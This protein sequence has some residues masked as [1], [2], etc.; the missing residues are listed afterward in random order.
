MLHH[1]KYVLSYVDSGP[2]LQTLIT[3][4]HHISLFLALFRD[5]CRWMFQHVK[6]FFMI[7]LR[8]RDFY[9]YARNIVLQ[10]HVT[11]RFSRS[12]MFEKEPALNYNKKG[13]TCS[14]IKFR[15]RVIFFFFFENSNIWISVTKSKL[16]LDFPLSGVK[17][18]E[19]SLCL[20]CFSPS[21][22]KISF[23]L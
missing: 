14:Y 13:F 3:K 2:C 1:A 6:Y 21:S 8:D 19:N 16:K 15:H 7:F 23:D 17:F 18:T 11:S 4:Y 9:H 22:R 10:G 20:T 5:C 12:N